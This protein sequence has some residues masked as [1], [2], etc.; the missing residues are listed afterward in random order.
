ML[1]SK[2][3]LA[4]CTMNMEWGTGLDM[5]RTIET[6]P[7]FWPGKNMLGKILKNIRGD[8]LEEICLQ[9]IDSGRSEK[10]KT[11][12]PLAASYSKKQAVE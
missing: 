4:E 5:R 12:S 8:L 11:V 7:D 2:S 3:E 9:Q 1:K 10:R 6:N